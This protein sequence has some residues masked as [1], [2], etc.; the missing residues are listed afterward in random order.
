M[1]I[2]NFN[3]AC[4]IMDN[5]RH[6]SCHNSCHNSGKF[7]N[8]NV[9]SKC[10]HSSNL[11]KS[12]SNNVNKHNE[13][14]KL[15]LSQKQFEDI[16]IKTPVTINVP[17]IFHIMFQTQLNINDLKNHINKNIMSV[18]NNDFNRSKINFSNTVYSQMIKRIF[19]RYPN[20]MSL[21][22]MQYNRLLNNNSMIKWNFYLQSIRLSLNNIISITGDDYNDFKIKDQSPAI[23]PDSTLNIWIA[24]T[25]NGILGISRFPWNDRDTFN[26][27]KFDSTGGK[28]HGVL[29]ASDVFGPNFEQNYP[30]SGYKTFS[31]EIGHYFGLLHTFDNETYK[32]NDINRN[33][34]AINYNTNSSED[35]I[36]DLI[37]DTSYQFDATTNYVSS[38]YA[39]TSEHMQNIFNN[40]NNYQPIFMNLMD[41]SYDS[42]LFFFTNDQQGKMVYLIKRYFPKLIHSN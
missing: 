29:I 36:G 10:G 1:N 37:V 24:P 11:C 40:N 16:N 22:L 18:I 34:I 8:N 13:V 25:S 5:P 23:N 30:Y 20:K 4:A 35:T 17:V 42:Q 26:H 41:Y 21:Y 39:Y 28:Y 27:L 7:T 38:N 14:C 31:H 6:N 9:T 2:F 15:I 12:F 19:A 33:N 32:T 3:Q